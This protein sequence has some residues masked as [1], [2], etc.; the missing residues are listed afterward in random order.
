VQVSLAQTAH[1]LRAMGR[2]ADGFAAPPVDR[3]PYLETVPSGFGE[4]CAIRHSVRLSRT[5]LREARPSM[6][7]G[8]HPA[9]WP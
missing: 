4:M 7:P 8:S 3:V 9:V 6:P 1:W 2:V 5:P